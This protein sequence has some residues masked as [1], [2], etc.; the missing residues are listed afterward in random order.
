VIACPAETWV[1]IIATRFFL[2]EAASPTF[3]EALKSSTIFAASVVWRGQHGHMLVQDP[4]IDLLPD[5]P[6]GPRRFKIKTAD[7]QERRS[8]VNSLLKDRYGWR[9]YQ[10]V[11][12]PTDPSVQ[13]FSL[14][15]VEDDVV[16]GT[17]T[18]A[19]DNP[20]RLGADEAFGAELDALRAEGRTLTEFTKLAIDP[21]SG[22]KR[23][24]ATLFHVAYIVA[25]RLRG[26]DMLLMEVNPRHVRYYER[27]LGARVLAGE[28]I[29][30]AVNAPAVLLGSEF[31]AIKAKIG[32]FGGQPELASHERS[33]YPFALSLREEAAVISRM[34]AKQRIQQRR[35]TDTGHPGEAMPTD[36]GS[37][38]LIGM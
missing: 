7:S 9:G 30:K 36:F 29:N 19:F 22:T 16:I 14:S 5:G 26:Y 15:A 31:S 23:V 38:D 12:L 24:L 28:R 21:L 8:R 17:I 32:E 20:G 37:T 18:V 11:S 10:Q 13:R 4:R 27:M 33:L 3:G 2:C 34:Q 6:A 25:H 1:G 35:L